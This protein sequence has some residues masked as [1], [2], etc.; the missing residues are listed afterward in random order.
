MLAGFIVVKKV[1]ASACCCSREFLGPQY[2]HAHENCSSM[3]KRLLQMLIKVLARNAAQK[4]N[5]LLSWRLLQM[6]IKV[7]ARNA[8]RK[9]N[10]LLSW[11]R[12]SQMLAALANSRVLNT[13]AHAKT[14][15][16]RQKGCCKCS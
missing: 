1:V 4:R 14:V 16:P 10:G 12:W 2:Y 7:L 3:T 13:L 11:K 5:G 8:A 9:R 15:R 6:L